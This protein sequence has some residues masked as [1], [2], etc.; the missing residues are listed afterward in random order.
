MSREL[1]TTKRERGTYYIT[2]SERETE[3]LY[4]IRRFKSVI[5]NC[6]SKRVKRNLLCYNGSFAI[7]SNPVGTSDTGGT[8][9]F[10]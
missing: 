10:V 6:T 9:Q 5:K 4:Y 3:S 2:D 8:N 1:A 7:H